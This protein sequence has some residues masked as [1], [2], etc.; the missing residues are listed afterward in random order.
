MGFN[1]IQRAV[2]KPAPDTWFL[3]RR[4]LAMNELSSGVITAEN[5]QGL[6]RAGPGRERGMDAGGLGPGPPR[7]GFAPL[8]S[9]HLLPAANEHPGVPPC[10]TSSCII[11]SVVMQT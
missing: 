1:D 2:L 10:S 8:P 7:L 4:Q 6:G 5:P 3:G 11:Y 9:T